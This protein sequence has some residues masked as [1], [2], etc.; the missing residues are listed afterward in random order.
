MSLILENM[1]IIIKTYEFI[2]GEYGEY[3]SENNRENT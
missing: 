3:Q 2:G 1:S